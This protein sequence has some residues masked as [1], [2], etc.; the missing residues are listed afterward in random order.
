MHRSITAQWLGR[1]AYA[2][3]HELQ[4][5]LLAARVRGEVGDRLLL[6]EH[7]PVITLGRGAKKEH[8]LASE[9]DRRRIGVD[10]VETGRGGDVTYHG[11]GQLVAYP[12]LDLKPDRCDVRRY[13][14]DL[15]RVMSKILTSY[16]IDS[17]MLPGS[18]NI[19]TWVDLESPR[20]WGGEEARRPAKVGAIGVRIS[21]WVTMHGFAL[22]VTTALS[23]FEMIVPCGIPDK[24]VTSIQL[25]AETVPTVEEVARA[26]LACF[27][28]VFDAD[29][30][31]EAAG[32]SDSPH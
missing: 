4:E 11:P 28:E 2:P 22:N 20:R 27:A 26:S 15:S 1:V 9:I 24:G 13:V 6:L 7:E 17:G 12:I 5:R 3:A 31:L 18:P 32:A 25:L 16:G 14:Q 10:L 19:G 23:A 29:V 21:R 8:V 30:T